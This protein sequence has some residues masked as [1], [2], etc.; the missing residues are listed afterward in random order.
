M[1]IYF[2]FNA[3][4]EQ[5]AQAEPTV[6]RADFIAP[7]VVNAAGTDAETVTLSTLRPRDPFAHLSYNFI[8]GITAAQYQAKCDEA[9]R[10]KP[11]I[12]Y[13]DVVDSVLAVFP[14]TRDDPRV[15]CVTL[16]GLEPGFAQVGAKPL[17]IKGCVTMLE[18]LE[19]YVPS[20]LILRGLQ[21]AGRTL[22]RLD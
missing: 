1:A 22:I 8:V 20:S 3:L 4:N 9:Q 16:F 7:P 5:G 10:M 13:P 19:A 17:E 12:D 15:Q 2:V 11:P 6:L 18:T 14:A 21:A